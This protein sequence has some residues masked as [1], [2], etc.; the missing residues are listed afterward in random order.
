MDINQK[1]VLQREALREQA[2]RIQE[3]MRREEEMHR[4]EEMKK[5]FYNPRIREYREKVADIT[6]KLTDRDINDEEREALLKEQEELSKR[7]S[8]MIPS[9]IFSPRQKEWFKEA[10][11]YYES[12][13]PVFRTAE[14]YHNFDEDG[15][16]KP[17]GPTLEQSKARSLIGREKTKTRSN[18]IKLWGSRKNAMRQQADFNTMFPELE[19]YEKN[20]NPSE[21]K[22]SGGRKKRNTRKIKKYRKTRNT[23]N[24]RKIKK[25]R[26]K[27][28]TS[29][30]KK[31]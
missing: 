22:S 17:D 14:L 2:I 20:D 18:R 4:E 11:E 21:D 27:R 28:N 9:D 10:D 30:I 15:R 3:N 1:W 5:T 25:Y 6:N 23:R 13:K 7:I 29:K 24:T 12:Q 8:D 31:I 16:L 19:E 26:K